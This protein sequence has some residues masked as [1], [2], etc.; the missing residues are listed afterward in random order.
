[1]KKFNVTLP[2]ILEVSHSVDVVVNA[3][4]EEEAIEIAC[5]KLADG[6]IER[7]EVDWTEAPEQEGNSAEEIKE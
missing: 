5:K 1:M 2:L 4:S 7:E 3:E 6:E